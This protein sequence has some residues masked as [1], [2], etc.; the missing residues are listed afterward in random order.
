MRWLLGLD[1]FIKYKCWECM[2]L[3]K[4]TLLSSVMAEKD[5]GWQFF[6][7]RHFKYKCWECMSIT[8]ILGSMEKRNTPPIL[9]SQE[10]DTLQIFY[11]LAFP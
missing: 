9:D 10:T 11:C 1:I 5:M 2:S 4:T 3:M 6:G 7:P 8:E